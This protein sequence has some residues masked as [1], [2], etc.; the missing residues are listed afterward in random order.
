MA[1]IQQGGECS[2]KN[3]QWKREKKKGLIFNI[4][5]K[6]KSPLLIP[7]ILFELFSIRK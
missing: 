4:S 2:G 7:F 6:R 5:L 1:V 3:K